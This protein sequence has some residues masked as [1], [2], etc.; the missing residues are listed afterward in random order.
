MHL[1][2][3]RWT[4]T[5]TRSR[6]SYFDISAPPTLTT[7]TCSACP[8]GW[9]ATPADGKGCFFFQTDPYKTNVFDMVLLTRLRD[10]QAGARADEAVQGA[11]CAVQWSP[12]PREMLNLFNNTMTGRDQWVQDQIAYAGHHRGL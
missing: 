7:R 4:C 2:G 9:A 6:T 3:T 1:D 11:L 10:H 12:S 5:R 8:V